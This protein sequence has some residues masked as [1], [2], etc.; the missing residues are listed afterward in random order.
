MEV[1]R[2]Y[3]MAYTLSALSL[4][5]VFKTFQNYK[6]YAKNQTGHAIKTL[7]SDNG[8]ELTSKK[9]N[10]FCT[11]HGITRQLTAPYTPEQMALVKERIGH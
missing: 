6:A 8:G 4:K 3:L 7:R 2:T 9:F 10:N 11:Q 1:V 5:E